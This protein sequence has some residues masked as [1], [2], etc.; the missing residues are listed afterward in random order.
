MSMSRNFWSKNCLVLALPIV[1]EKVRRW[2]MR[3]YRY[4]TQI[5]RENSE[6]REQLATLRRKF[7]RTHRRE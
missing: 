3:S 2:L 5:E 7:R 1:S 6:L 4:I